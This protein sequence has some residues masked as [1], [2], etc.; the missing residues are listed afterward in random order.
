MQYVFD[1]GV[2]VVLI[3]CRDVLDVGLFSDVGVYWMYVCMHFVVDVR[4]YWLYVC[5]GCTSV[6]DVACIAC[7]YVFDIGMY[8]I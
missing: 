2:Y 8:S 1:V 3:R 6:S 4:M 5:I 7:T